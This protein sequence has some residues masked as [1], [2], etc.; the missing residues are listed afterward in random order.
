M[1]RE[2]LEQKVTELRD[3][4]AAKL[5]EITDIWLSYDLMDIMDPRPP[6]EKLQSPHKIGDTYVTP[7]S[8]IDDNQVRIAF[9]TK[10]DIGDEDSSNEPTSVSGSPSGSE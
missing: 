10:F 5:G 4:W 8:A 2:Q 7:F 9:L 6:L 1:T 3:A